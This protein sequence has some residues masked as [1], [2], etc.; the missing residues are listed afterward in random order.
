M[1]ADVRSSR[2][3]R[4]STRLNSSHRTISYAVFCLKPPPTSALY[5]LSLHDALPI[6]TAEILAPSR[7]SP[8]F[9]ALLVRPLIGNRVY[10]TVGSRP[11]APAAL[12]LCSLLPLLPHGCGREELSARSEEHTSELQSPY[13]LVCRL[14]LEAP[15]D[16]RALPSF[17]TRRSSD[18]DRRDIGPES[19]FAFFL[20][21]SR[22]TADRESRVR[23]GRLSS[24]GARCAAPV[25]ATSP[26]T[27][28]LR[29]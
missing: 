8:F 16:L 29:T 22:P 19:L 24:S 6:S 18:L 26:P 10:A 2:R 5:P 20:R 17:P 12:R 1:A 7:C 11:R 13:D 15:P 28:W 3:D 9:F 27:P 14:L 25:F 4:K 23:D 21:A